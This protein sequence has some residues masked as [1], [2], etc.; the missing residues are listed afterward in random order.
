M[1]GLTKGALDLEI[2]LF[3]VM[4]VVYVKTSSTDRH[5]EFILLIFSGENDNERI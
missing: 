3:L 5:W 4:A 2:T 1:K